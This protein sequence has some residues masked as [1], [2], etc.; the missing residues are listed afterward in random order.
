[1]KKFTVCKDLSGHEA[2]P[3]RLS[4]KNVRKLRKIGQYF[5]LDLIKK[6]YTMQ[7]LKKMVAKTKKTS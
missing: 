3:A 4:V 5:N 1:M 2:R 7:E 6:R